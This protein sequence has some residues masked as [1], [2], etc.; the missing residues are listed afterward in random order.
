MS[1]GNPQIT[2]DQFAAVELRVAR[3]LNVQPFPKA[4]K[5]S[6]KVQLDLGPLGEKWSSAQITNYAVDELIG[7][8]VVCV[9]NFPPRNI[10]GFLSEVLILGAADSDGRVIL[11]SPRSAVAPGE[12][13]Y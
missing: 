5:P 1:D 4:R 9:C 2:Y 3:V 12:R 13:V 10:A 7:T 11:L 6:W 8:L